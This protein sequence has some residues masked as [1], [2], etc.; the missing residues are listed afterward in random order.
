MPE[1]FTISYSSKH[2][3][4]I[5]RPLF[6]VIHE[7]FLPYQRSY[8]NKMFISLWGFLS[9][10]ATPN[11]R[12]RLHHTHTHTHTLTHTSVRTPLNEWSAR[13]RSR[14]VHTTQQT[15]ETKI[16]DFGGIRTHDPSN[17]AATDL[18]LTLH[19]Y[20]DQLI[21]GTQEL[22]YIVWYTIEQN[23]RTVLNYYSA[24]YNC[25]YFDSWMMRKVLI[26]A[27]S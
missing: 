25:S 2:K 19:G 23:I 27:S 8:Q 17:P 3:H 12:P 14:Y 1:C 16:R 5:L 24:V 15:H 13:R 22:K 26:N 4:C 6:M 10:G 20:R 7:T 9:C 11:P 18:R 21:W